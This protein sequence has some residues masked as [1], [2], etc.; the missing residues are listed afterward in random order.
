MVVSF[1]STNT[2]MAG[3]VISKPDTKKPNPK[4]KPMSG[5][6]IPPEKSSKKGYI[7]AGI[8]AALAAITTFFV[9]KKIKNKNQNQQNEP[10]DKNFS[11]TA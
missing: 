10:Q 7:I 1:K 8:I 4:N 5:S 11:K 9:M 2:P 3:K 6:V